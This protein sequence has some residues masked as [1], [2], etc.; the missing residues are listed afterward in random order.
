MNKLNKILIYVL[1]LVITA[2]LMAGSIYR[3][4]SG[5]SWTDAYKPEPKEPVYIELP[6]YICEEESSETEPNTEQDI[7]NH[8][9]HDPEDI[10][11]IARVVMSEASI[12]S[13]DAKYAVAS[14]I[15]NRVNDDNFPDSVNDVIYTPYQY[16]HQDNGEPT[17]E[18]YEAARAAMD[19]PIDDILYFRL[20][21]YHEWATDEFMIDGTYFSSR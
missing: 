14:T 5:Y 20:D 4:A 15:V 6:V 7:P 8:N 2:M 18:C 1:A 12:L 21:H 9:I 3:D 11:L 17:D 10:A 19:D 13:Y 16:S